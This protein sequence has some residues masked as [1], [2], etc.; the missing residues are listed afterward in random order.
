MLE[1]NWI[2]ITV[3][4]PEPIYQ[5]YPTNPRKKRHMPIG[6][7]YNLNYSYEKNIINGRFLPYG[8]GC[9]KH[10]SCDTCPFED[11]IASITNFKKEVTKKKLLAY[12]R[13]IVE[14]PDDINEAILRRIKKNKVEY[15]KQIYIILRNELLRKH[16][17]KA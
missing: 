2:S 13:H 6:G 4:L 14:I 11:C 15:D 10:S 12:Q 1:R 3:R 16:E 17:K 7:L 9:K 8:T 5:I